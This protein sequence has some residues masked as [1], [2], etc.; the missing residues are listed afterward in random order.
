MHAQAGSHLQHLSALLHPGLHLGLHFCLRVTTNA[1]ARVSKS[2]V[3]HAMPPAGPFVADP[4]CADHATVI[5]QQRQTTICSS[6]RCT[7][8]QAS[9]ARC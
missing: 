7:T 2:T 8:T 3:H 9:P 6:H 1:Q 5:T 4:T